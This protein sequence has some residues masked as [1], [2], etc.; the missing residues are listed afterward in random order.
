MT[1]FIHYQK[2]RVWVGPR[3]DSLETFRKP[4]FKHY[5]VARIS[6]TVACAERIKP[7]CLLNIESRCVVVP[8]AHGN[9][10]EDGSLG[11]FNVGRRTPEARLPAA[12]SK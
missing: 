6:A 3:F 5:P 7:S 8:V 12:L 11:F 4:G 10:V 1:L 2:G 9:N